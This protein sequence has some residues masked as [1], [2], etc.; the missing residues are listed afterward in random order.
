MV[1][2]EECTQFNYGK[3]TLNSHLVVLELNGDILSSSSYAAHDLIAV[4]KTE[5]IYTGH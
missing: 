5:S 1:K 2:V 3:C 4:Q